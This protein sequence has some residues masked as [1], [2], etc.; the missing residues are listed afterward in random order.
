MLHAARS[1]GFCSVWSHM[2]ALSHI[3]FFSMPCRLCA[4]GQGTA[5]NLLGLPAD[6]AELLATTSDTFRCPNCLAGVQQ[7][8]GMGC[9][10]QRGLQ[11]L[12]HTVC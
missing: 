10:C 1:L 9:A 12:S 5:C 8:S 2:V 7:A 3:G 6:L 4:A 11:N